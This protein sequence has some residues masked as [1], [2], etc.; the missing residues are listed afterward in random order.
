M[1]HKRGCYRCRLKLSL[2]P[3]DTFMS[4]R[5]NIVSVTATQPLQLL[6]RKGPVMLET[7][8]ILM[9]LVAIAGAFALTI[10][11]VISL[12]VGNLFDWLILTFG[13]EEAVERLKRESDGR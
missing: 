6:S 5:S 1:S 4:Q 10:W 13:N 11:K 3:L 8:I 2:D 7:V 12:A 9:V